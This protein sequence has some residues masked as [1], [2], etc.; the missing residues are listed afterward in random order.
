M[1]SV[2][3]GASG[4]FTFFK[5]NGYDPIRYY[6]TLLGLSVNTNSFLSTLLPDV[7]SSNKC[8]SFYVDW[9]SPP[10]TAP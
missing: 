10:A 9:N 1:K 4:D 2:K 6:P 7:P 3:N 8:K 5:V